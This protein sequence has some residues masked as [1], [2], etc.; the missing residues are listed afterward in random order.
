[1][2]Y[3]FDWSRIDGGDLKFRLKL[4]HWRLAWSYINGRSWV[5]PIQ[6]RNIKLVEFHNATARADLPAWRHWSRVR[7]PWAKIWN[8]SHFGAT[9][10]MP[11][12]TQK[13]LTTPSCLKSCAGKNVQLPPINQL[14]AFIAT[15]ILRNEAKP[16]CPE[17]G[18]RVVNGMCTNC[19]WTA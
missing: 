2:Q 1:M 18:H 4:L 16:E 14:T 10:L 5:G 7:K 8:R 15:P 12:N 6:S 9:L 17:C 13:I 11:S 3:I 19:P